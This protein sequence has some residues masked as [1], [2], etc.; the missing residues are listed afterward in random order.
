MDSARPATRL[1]WMLLLGT[2]SGMAMAIVAR[3]R[4]TQAESIPVERPSPP[5]VTTS[6]PPRPQSPP[7]L[8]APPPHPLAS[9]PVRW[10]LFASIFIGVLVGL[11]SVERRVATLILGVIMVAAV[12]YAVSR[13]TLW[14]TIASRTRELLS[15]Q[16]G[17]W[18]IFAGAIGGLIV[19]F[20]VL[21]RPYSTAA[22]ALM[23]LGW[24]ALVIRSMRIGERLRQIRLEAIIEQVKAHW[25]LRWAVFGGVAFVAYHLLIALQHPYSTLVLATLAVSL[26]PVMVAQAR[27]SASTQVVLMRGLALVA[28]VMAVASIYAFL[29]PAEA[30]FPDAWKLLVVGGVSLLVAVHVG[31]RTSIALPPVPAPTTQALT[32]ARLEA[33]HYWC[34]GLGLILM[35]LLAEAN[36]RLFDILPLVYMSVHVQLILLILSITLISVGL[37]GIQLSLSRIPWRTVAL[38]GGI[39]AV[40]LFLR[41]WQVDMA[42]RQFID[43]LNFSAVVREFWRSPNVP[44]LEPMS[45]IAAFPYIY[46]YFQAHTIELFGRNLVGL[47]A[48]SVIFGGL[49]IPALYL[50]GRWL[51]DRKTG[52]IAALFLATFPP[53]MHFSRLGMNNIADPLFGTL[54]FA[55][56]ARGIMR[57]RRVDY[58]LG[59][60]MLGL[61][62]YFYEGGRL[63][64]VPTVIVWLLGLVWLW[65]PRIHW[66]HVLLVLVTVLI[67]AIPIYFTLTVTDRSYAARLIEN[68]TA[69]SGTYWRHLFDNGDLMAHIRLRVLH[70]FL[71]YIVAAEGSFFYRGNFALILPLLVPGFLLGVGHCLARLRRPGPLLLLI[72]WPAVTA[73]NSLLVAAD[74]APR[75]VAV[76]PALMLLLAV[77]I[78][79][80]LPMLIPHLSRARTVVMV[81]LVIAFAGFQADYYFND[82]LP[83]FN[84][85][86]RM[87]NPHPDAQDAALRSINFPP[88]TQVHIISEIPANEGYTRGFLSLMN[89]QVELYTLRPRDV[90]VEYLRSLDPREDQAFFI[91]EGHDSLVSLIENYMFVLPP[92]YS[93]YPDIPDYQQY[94]L[95]YAP[96]LPGYNESRLQRLHRVRQRRFPMPVP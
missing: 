77:G 1:R 37:G 57:S 45:S 36:G 62:H 63:V 3:M 67:V 12:G 35:A 52:L 2:V 81:V 25:W 65:G 26:L 40:G 75:Y 32:P 28:V 58:V 91:E 80:T 70:P 8:P 48:A 56:V 76:F 71:L 82:H 31:L 68:N 72:W 92:Q 86:T 23:L 15:H 61:T 5:P 85:Q 49:T 16:L 24:A 14:Q 66:R 38:V 21:P 84:Y 29:Q 87:G 39:T 30:H 96:S 9:R 79:Y 43:E 10:M 73:G 59:G 53:H 13:S 88:H 64:F 27:E 18:L 6:V 19:A 69:L 74:H 51:F 22:L 95:Y 78:R 46:P 7:Q 93:P 47:R 34:F 11:L 4:G 44:L 41:F 42:L 83:L 50:L 33:G 17:R 55:L 60:A 20:M 94:P 54:G 90:T 89:D